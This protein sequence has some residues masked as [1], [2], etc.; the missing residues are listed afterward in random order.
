MAPTR[1]GSPS[2]TPLPTA[3]TA[4]QQSQCRDDMPELK[5]KGVTIVETFAEAFPM[6][7]TRI[8]I[9]APTMEWAL[10]SAPQA[11]TEVAK[12]VMVRAEISAHSMVGAVMMIRVPTMGKASANV[13]TMV[14]PLT[15]SSGMSSR[16]WDCCEAV[17]AVGDGIGDAEPGWVDAIIAIVERL[18]ALFD[19]RVEAGLDVITCLLY[20][21]PSP[22][23]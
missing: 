16:H 12:P 17:A 1:P 19:L 13:S 22:R 15:F 18:H 20:T 14:T 10:I 5:V 21:S 6:V 4:S 2:P 3:A 23:D 7:G 8:I 9:T 11:I